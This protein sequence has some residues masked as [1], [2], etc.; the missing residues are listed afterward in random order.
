MSSTPPNVAIAAWG[1]LG[2]VAIIGQALYRLVPLALEPFTD[3]S[4]EAL[5]IA[6]AVGWSLTAM[7]SEGYKGFQKAFAPRVVARAVY[8]AR[9]PRPVFVALAP[10]FCFAFF[11]ATRR[12]LIVAWC[13]LLGIV[14]LVL[15]VH[16]LD[17]PWRGVVDTGV[18]A[19]LLWGE[20]AIVVFFVRAL[21]G[22]PMPVPPDVPESSQAPAAHS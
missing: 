3:G 8:L 12:R 6:V 2:V 1:T 5:H 11:H 22:H 14:G 15:A 19:G 21:S 4:A 13:F 10:L 18:V 7:Y 9:N 20:I 16:Q 17:Q